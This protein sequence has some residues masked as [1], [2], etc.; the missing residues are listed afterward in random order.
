MELPTIIAQAANEIVTVTGAG[1]EIPVWLQAVLTVVSSLVTLI[2]IPFLR[3][4]A[5]AAAAEVTSHEMSAVTNVMTQ[6]QIISERLKSFLLRNAA[7]IAEKKWPVLATEIATGNIQ[8]PDVV[9]G[10]LREWGDELKADAI[11]YFKNQG[12]ELVE[13]VGDKY[14]DQFVEWAANSTSPFVG[15]ETAV[16]VLKGKVSNLIIEKGVG[17]IREKYLRDGHLD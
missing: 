1:N 14:L 11:D 4:K 2:L 7:R 12:I 5:A 15:K 13:A 6:R 16:E 10:V 3:N 8:K 9:K 17:W